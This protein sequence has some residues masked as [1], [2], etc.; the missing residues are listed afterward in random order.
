[1][2]EQTLIQPGGAGARSA[3]L[4]ASLCAQATVVGLALLAPLVFTDRLPVVRMIESF[5]A[6][7]P[8]PPPPFV[9][10]VAAERAPRAI[11]AQSSGRTLVLP[12]R[13][14]DLPQTII[15][16]AP[17]VPAFDNMIGVI[18]ATGPRDAGRD[19]VLRSIFAHTPQVAPPPKPA[20]ERHVAK[21]ESPTIR[22]RQGGNVQ[23]ALILRRV[24]PVY[25]P[26]AKQARIS[27]VVHLE[28]IIGRDGTVQQLRVVSGHPLLVKAAL[29]AVQQWLYR[30]TLLNGEPV[31]VISPIDVFFHLN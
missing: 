5:V 7:P 11:P 22:L 26:L 12:T 25:P 23:E 9:Q 1:M 15:D 27:G 3:S 28:G 20:E 13:I 19:G 6:P 4:A 14:P 21:T 31:E 8:P 24:I 10:I 2:F 18:G 16:E 17:P 29:E 30:P